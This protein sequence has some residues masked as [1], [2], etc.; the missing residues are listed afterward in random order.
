MNFERWSKDLSRLKAG[1]RRILKL[2]RCLSAVDSVL[3]EISLE[4]RDMGEDEEPQAR[5]IQKIRNKIRRVY[6][7]T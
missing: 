2:E 4:Y 6:E 3:S 1:R 7:R 5:R